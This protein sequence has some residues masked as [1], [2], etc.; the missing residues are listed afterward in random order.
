MAKITPVIMSGGAG[1]RLWPVS[2]LARPKQFHRLGGDRTLIQETALRTQGPGFEPP[3]VVCNAAHAE[4]AAA[5]LAEAGIKP[6]I[7]LEPVARNTAP[8]V[9]SAALIASQADPA[10]LIL[11][12]PADHA[13]PDR[14]GFL[15]AVKAG[16][17]A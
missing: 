17:P 3:M 12:M 14:A 4:I 5:Q 16:T 8:A 2:R 10:A 6:R 11:V 13:V 1:T 9:A 15:E 7:V